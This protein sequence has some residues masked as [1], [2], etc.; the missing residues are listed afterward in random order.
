MFVT[1]IALALAAAA[2]QE[3][4]AK[5]GKKEP[6]EVVVTAS[7]V[8]E[9]LADVPA[10]VTTLKRE[11]IEEA[12]SL[13]L[14][15][16]LDRIPG[17]QNQ[18]VFGSDDVRISIRGAGIRSNF[19]VRSLIV[20]LDGIP[21]TEADGQTRLDMIDLNAVER[22]EVVRGPASTI[23]GGNA[24]GGVINLI[25]RQGAKGFQ[26]D[27]QGEAGSF[28]FHK[29]YVSASGG[30][31]AYDYF[32]S[33]S[34]TAREGYRDHSDTRGER[35]HF[36]AR[37]ALD[38]K[39]DVR[40]LVGYANV[41]IH[42]PG[43]LTEAQM[44]DDPRQAR[45]ANVTNDWGRFD[46]RLRVA[47]LYT[48]EV[49]DVLD[50]GATVFFD[51]RDLDHPIFQFLEINRLEA[52]GDLRGHLKAPLFGRAHSLIGGLSF[53]FQEMDEQDY[54]NVGGHRGALAADEDARVRNFGVYLQ[55]ELSI[56][57][58][59]KLTGGVRWSR[60]TFELDDHFLSDGDQSDRIGFREV[61]PR[62]GLAWI[63]AEGVTLF[64]NV[65]TGFETATLSEQTS[66]ASGGFVGLDPQKVVSFELGSRGEFKLV[67]RPVRYEAAV[68]RMKFR[69]EII[70]ITVGF[71]TTF[72]NAARTVHDGAE[73]ALGIDLVE[74]LAF[75]AAYT[76]SDFEFTEGPSDGNEVP[77][78]PR[79]QIFSSL[80]W[81]LPVPDPWGRLSAALEARRVEEFFVDDAN[82]V[83]NDA[84]TT[85]G[86][87]LSHRWESFGAFFQV[88]NLTD[89]EYSEFVQ[90][91]GS[92]NQFFHPADARAYYVGLS[93]SF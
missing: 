21:L 7:K 54:A 65:A 12:R 69:D 10:S 15:A 55:D 68:Y 43:P 4:A 76:F 87:R 78:V 42:M 33:A 60:I 71:T 31:D 16:A 64:G 85:L 18:N 25:S 58:D 36:N 30:G 67:D 39:S 9:P 51:H 41:D 89:E 49:L 2:G 79:H 84:Y 81:R 40:F 13:S 56:L 61:S 47:A 66:G 59:L 17:L 88:E 20:T 50:V 45:A 27:L 82:T 1:M 29:E 57:E 86:L 24:V 22:I 14:D 92:F 28:G 34:H 37:M 46:D 74:G 23:Y 6:R 11:A 44:E 3:E 53:Q 75:Y 52:G 5:D 80:E 26:A 83:E 19:G 73:L 72:Q 38:D 8:E 32:F 63:P 77:G 90:I 35:V 48:R 91:N 93:A 70:P 62:L